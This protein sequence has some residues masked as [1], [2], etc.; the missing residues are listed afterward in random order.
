MI[1]VDDI[2]F[3]YDDNR[4]IFQH[5]SLTIRR[6][7]FIAILG[8]NGSG[9]TTL[10]RLLKGL[11]V[12]DCGEIR[13]DGISTSSIR[14]PSEIHRRVGLIFQNPETQIVAPVVWEDV[15]FGPNN[16]GLPPQKARERVEW[17]LRQVNL[18]EERYS[19]PHMLSGGQKQRLA[20]A[21]VLAMRPHYLILDEATAML[22]PHTR[23]NILETIKTLH[24][25]ES[26]AVVLITHRVEE[27]LTAEKILILSRGK[28][29]WEGPPSD[30]YRHPEQL[31]Q[32]NIPLPPAVHLAYRLT[33]FG[34][35]PVGDE[36]RLIEQ[37]LQRWHEIRCSSSPE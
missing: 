13:I 35:K 31:A 7:E 36:E 21:G 12:P 37:I 32:H 23:S 6:G 34:I 4:K 16:L 19:N 18:F 10:A 5:F 3:G 15:H 24:R 33:R 27:A 1:E 22:C 25:N 14:N 11:L 29:A 28:I 20:I 9:K 8:S 30:L 26:I 17:A 2:T